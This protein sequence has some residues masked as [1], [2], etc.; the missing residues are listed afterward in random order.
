MRHIHFN[1]FVDD[2]IKG[3]LR[4]ILNV[5]Q[6]GVK[7]KGIGKR[8]AALTDVFSADLTGKVIESAED[9]G[10]DLLQTLDRARLKSGEQTTFKEGISLF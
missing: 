6:N 1:V 5:W 4:H 2:L 3:G 7:I 10:V 9:I 8:E